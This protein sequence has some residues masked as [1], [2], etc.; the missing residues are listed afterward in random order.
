MIAADRGV[1]VLR[2]VVGAWFVKAVWTKF[3]V[4]YLWDAIPS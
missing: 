4:A 1:A 3:T 2:I